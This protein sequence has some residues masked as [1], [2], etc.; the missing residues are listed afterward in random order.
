MEHI[1]YLI[2]IA[3]T[4]GAM[5]MDLISFRIP[6]GYILCGMAMGL[7]SSFIREGV[8]GIL[9]GIIGGIIPII[10]LFVLFFIK[11]MGGGDIKLFSAI[12][13]FIGKSIGFILLYSF[14]FGGILSIIYLIRAFVKSMAY[15]SSNTHKDLQNSLQNNIN[16]NSRKNSRENSRDNSQDIYK[17]LCYISK[18]KLSPLK[19]RI[20]FSIAIFAGVICFIVTGYV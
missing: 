20:H 10:L 11:A 1:I 19:A 15:H 7:I 17:G 14:I 4:A 18:D 13:C 16:N 6:N 2:L 5:V 9:E 3:Y 8:H 12:G